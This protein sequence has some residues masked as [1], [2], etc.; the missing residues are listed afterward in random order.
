MSLFEKLMKN[1]SAE[2]LTE[3]E[4]NNRS[5]IP[6]DVPVLN[7]WFGGHLTGAK[8]GFKG[9]MHVWA[10]PSKHFKTLFSLQGVKAFMDNM[11]DPYC[12]FFDNEG[13]AALEYFE[14]TG[15]DPDRVIRVPFSNIEELKFSLVEY[16]ESLELKDNVV[17]FIDSI[18]NA[19]SKKE[20]KDAVE[21]NSAADMT[22]AKELKGFGRIVTP[23]LMNKNIPLFAVNHVYDSIGMFPTTI[24]G[25]GQGIMLSANTV[26]FIGKRKIKDGK[27]VVGFDFML[28]SEKSRGIKEGVILPI[29]VTYERGI[30]KYSALLDI[31]INTGHVIKPKQGWYTRVGVEGDKNWRAKDTSCEE[32]WGPLLNDTGFTDAVHNMFSLSSDITTLTLA[33]GSTVDID[34]GEVVNND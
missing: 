25:G 15:I 30:D 8:A 13:G 23:Y 17:I 14:S 26:T 33:D 6:F 29:T 22:R 3:A 1:K 16:L 21:Q 19:A 34:T 9:G 4:I 10:A 7:L 31:A 32:F 28:K 24:M 2:V 18:G 20:A 11:D 5:S 27:D 12:L